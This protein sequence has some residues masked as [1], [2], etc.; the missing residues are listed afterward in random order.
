MK[1]TPRLLLIGLSLLGGSAPVSARASYRCLLVVNGRTFL[2]GSC[3]FE[4][5][6]KD[7]SFMFSKKGN[8]YF[9]YLLR[10][11]DEGE[12]WGSWNESP[13]SSHADASLGLMRRQGACW[14]NVTR[15][16]SGGEPGT[17]KICAWKT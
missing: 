7:G 17:N 16:F 1:I 3:D 15:G 10:Y 9:A 4:P 12:T 6:D 5:I 14:I 13:D 2:A 11:P 8:P